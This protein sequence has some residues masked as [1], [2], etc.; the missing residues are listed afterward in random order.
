MHSASQLTTNEHKGLF[1]NKTAP[2][3]RLIVRFKQQYHSKM[4]R[5]LV[6]FL[7][8]KIISNAKIDTTSIAFQLMTYSTFDQFLN[9]ALSL[10]HK[11]STMFKL[12]VVSVTK[13]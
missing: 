1:N 2:T 9:S 7:L 3:L 10:G 12:V 11:S 4:Q 13:E 6:N 8:S 5:D